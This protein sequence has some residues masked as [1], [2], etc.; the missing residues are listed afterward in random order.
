MR[1]NL[2]R[3]VSVTSWGGDSF[4]VYCKH[5][6]FDGQGSMWEFV[7]L[8]LPCV[9][10][11]TWLGQQLPNLTDL[12]RT[13]SEFFPLT[14]PMGFRKSP[15]GKAVCSWFPTSQ[16]YT[17]ELGDM[18]SQWPQLSSLVGPP[19]LPCGTDLSPPSTALLLASSP[20]QW[21]QGPHGTRYPHVPWAWSPFFHGVFGVKVP[22]K[23]SWRKMTSPGKI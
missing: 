2:K 19:G 3:W 9:V 8:Y 7:A 15:H 1:V 20:R 23:A 11:S 16:L 13:G 4:C 5:T 21:G 10:S 14:F 12:P 18:P 17:R 22:R 6:V